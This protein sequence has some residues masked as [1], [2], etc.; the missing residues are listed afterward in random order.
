M[1]PSSSALVFRSIFF[2]SLR[3]AV[4]LEFG[5]KASLICLFPGNEIKFRREFR[6][7]GLILKGLYSNM[8]PQH[9]LLS[10]TGLYSLEFKFEL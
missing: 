4:L 7:G 10:H 8:H 5:F 3:V 2:R 6:C 1:T 9:W